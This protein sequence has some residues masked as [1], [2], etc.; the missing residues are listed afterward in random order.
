[1]TKLAKSAALETIQGNINKFGHHIYL[2]SGGTSPRFSYSIG[3]SKKV[4]FEL[5]IAGATFY[6]AEEVKLIINEMANKLESQI[7]WDELRVEIASLG[8]FIL[9]KMDKSWSAALM[10]GALDF[11]DQKIVNGLQIVPDK[12]H[13]TVDIPDLTEVRSV[14][15]APVWQWLDNPWKECVPNKAVAI[16]NL[17][18]LQGAPITEAMRWEEGEWEMFAGAGPDV[19]KG[20]IRIV[21]LSTLLAVDPSIN[22]VIS[23][24]VGKGLW[25]DPVDLVWQP[26]N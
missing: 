14:K 5:V 21:P 23:L 24:G 7:A 19:N 11:Y 22:A 4:G 15:T 8:K 16:T 25:R 10:L 13:W 12:E 6:S 20:D 26:W 2:V 18:A 17:S 1:M 9:R 3:L